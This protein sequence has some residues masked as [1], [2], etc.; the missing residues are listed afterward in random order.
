[1]KDIG[2]SFSSVLSYR[3][4]EEVSEVLYCSNRAG[5]SGSGNPK[6]YSKKAARD[7]E[8]QSFK[9]VNAAVAVA[10]VKRDNDEDQLVDVAES[11]KL[12]RVV[13]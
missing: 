1:M 7:R 3:V 10:D 8:M 5:V 6:A 11:M 4:P 2:H 13:A 9:R 12:L